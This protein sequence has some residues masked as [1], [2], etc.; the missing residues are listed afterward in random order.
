MHILCYV[1]CHCFLKNKML[2]QLLKFVKIHNKR[3]AAK[4]PATDRVLACWSCKTAFTIS[5]PQS[6]LLNVAVAQLELFVSRMD[7]EFVALLR[8]NIKNV[9]P[10]QRRKNKKILL[11]VLK[12]EITRVVRVSAPSPSPFFQR[13]H[14]LA[15]TLRLCKQIYCLGGQCQLLTGVTQL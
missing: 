6:L 5:K 12:E 8:H 14:Y 7:P 3:S 1:I 2:I 9:V 15:T 10:P 11:P 13:A 4:P